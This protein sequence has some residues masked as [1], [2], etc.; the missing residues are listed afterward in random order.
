[1]C[2]AIGRSPL[3]APIR[4]SPDDYTSA[5]D[6]SQNFFSP[7]TVV[8]P[9]PGQMGVPM[10]SPPSPLI[11]PG[12]LSR[13]GPQQLLGHMLDSPT[14]QGRALAHARTQAQPHPQMHGGH[15]FHSP[16][17]RKRGSEKH[18]APKTEAE[19][20][21]DSVLD[22]LPEPKAPG[23]GRNR[24]RVTTAALTGTPVSVSSS[25]AVASGDAES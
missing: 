17:R 12:P 24:R 5:D 9:T 10:P 13:G 22:A 25:P 16:P 14:A 18:G 8:I 20:L 19:Q 1:M 15:T 7:G 11:S 3:E 2:R 23:Q 21:L 6:L 4:L